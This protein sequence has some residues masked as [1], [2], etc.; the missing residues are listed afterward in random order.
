MSETIGY[1]ISN[2]G[3]AMERKIGITWFNTYICNLKCA[4]CAARA[5][6]IWEEHEPR[7][8]EDWIQLFSNPP[9]PFSWFCVSGRELSCFPKLDSVLDVI[10]CPI[11]LESNLEVHPKDWISEDNLK[12]TT[13]FNA[14]YHHLPTY[15]HREKWMQKLSYLKSINPTMLLIFKYDITQSNNITKEVD[16]MNAD[17]IKHGANRTFNNSLCEKL[18]YHKYFLYSGRHDQCEFGYSRIV[19]SPIGD[20]YRCTGHIY[21]GVYCMGNIFK[22]GWGILYD[23]IRPCE[24]AGC[25]CSVQPTDKF[26]QKL[27]EGCKW[28]SPHFYIPRLKMIKE[29]PEIFKY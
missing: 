27:T 4:E 14:T 20:V 29:H 28:E 21:Q 9:I 3:L 10:K 2:G 5:L 7:P 23:S 8:A 26:D 6:P 24:I 22:D 15:E 16:E 18:L 11:Y 17:A 25:T 12:K 1:C 13:I 19:I